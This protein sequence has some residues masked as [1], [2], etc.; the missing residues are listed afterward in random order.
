MY[1]SDGS[2]AQYK[3]RKNSSTSTMNKIMVSLMN[4]TSLEQAIGMDKQME[5]EGQ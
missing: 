5:W 3:N 2:T 4:V 1:F